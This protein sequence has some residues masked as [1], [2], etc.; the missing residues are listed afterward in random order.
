MSSL[1]DTNVKL[2]RLI[3]IMSSPWL[4]IWNVMYVII[5]ITIALYSLF[6]TKNIHKMA[7][8]S[9]NMVKL[10]PEAIRT[11]IFKKPV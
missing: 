6:Y 5:L 9:R 2:D 10:S 3:D 4:T 1:D 7:K 8:N 11:L